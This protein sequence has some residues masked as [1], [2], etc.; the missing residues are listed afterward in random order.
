MTEFAHV[1]NA[2][3]DSLPPGTTLLRG[4]FRVE[5]FLN[6][7]GFGI[8]YLA[9]NSLERRVVLKECYSSSMCCRT[10]QQ[11]RARS[12][13]QQL[14]FDTVVRLFGEEARRL[15]K[16]YHPNIVGVHDVF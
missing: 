4:Q 7:G 6:A 13:N 16:L 2:P 14:E 5:S 10:D 1:Q 12:R 9:R 11:V 15:A 8:T 3:P